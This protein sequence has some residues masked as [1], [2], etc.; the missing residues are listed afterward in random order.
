MG[1]GWSRNYPE[2]LGTLS[3]STHHICSTI[4]A[5]AVGVCKCLRFEWLYVEVCYGQPLRVSCAH[6][7][8]ENVLTH[9]TTIYWMVS[10]LSKLNSQRR[11]CCSYRSATRDVFPCFSQ[12]VSTAQA[13]PC[14]QLEHFLLQV[15]PQLGLQSTPFPGL[16]SSSCI[17]GIAL[18]PNSRSM[19]RYFGAILREVW[20]RVQQ[21]DNWKRRVTSHLF[22]LFSCHTIETIFILCLCHKVVLADIQSGFPRH[23]RCIFPHMCPHV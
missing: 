17:F 7:S 15:H 22:A 18:Q 1:Q 12:E 20:H 5:W 13:L 11:P 6:R 10:V 2:S 16:Q 14:Y 3:S 8:P 19:V 9:C 4:C 21:L 23:W